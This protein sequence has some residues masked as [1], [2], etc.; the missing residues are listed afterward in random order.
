MNTAQE[1]L[2]GLVIVGAG[3]AGI[4]VAESMRAAGYKKP[5][6]ILGDEVQAPYHRPPLS[7][8]WL[9]GEVSSDQLTLRSPESLE[10]KNIKLL[11][12]VKVASIQRIEKT[13]QTTTGDVFYYENLVISTGASPR[14]PNLANNQAQGVFT[15][16]SI[17]DAAAITQKME[18]CLK[19][20][21]N[22]IVIGGGFIGLEVAATARK[23]NVSTTLIESAPRLLERTLAPILSDWYAKLHQSHGVNLILN[24]QVSSLEVNSKNHITAIF[25][26]NHTRI[27]CGMV[28]VGVGVSANDSLAKEAGLECQNGIVV[29]AYGQT[30]DPHIFAAGDCCITRLSNKELVRLESIQ[31]A[32]EQAKR[33]AATLMGMPTPSFTVPWFWSDQYD[34]KLQIAGIS[35][36]ATHW[37]IIGDMSSNSF[38]IEHYLYNQ[39][40]AVDSINSIKDHLAARK[41]LTFTKSSAF[42]TKEL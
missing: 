2:Q 19:K 4:T 16:R 9:A 10:R 17:N 33:V 22:L 30:S 11:L 23:K 14:L 25:L 8:G 41:R 20:D 18:E 21:Q 13:V 1:T 34:K 6:H 32:T 5:I 7:K 24:T 26:Q 3:L 29:N 12:G 37:K 28:V 39:L 27:P 15:L 31:S 40:I 38:S 36:G 42:L 35:K